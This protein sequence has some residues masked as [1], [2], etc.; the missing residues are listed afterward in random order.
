[1]SDI[2]WKY[3]KNPHVGSN[4][5]I[6]KANK[7]KTS[8][9]YKPAYTCLDCGRSMDPKKGAKKRHHFAHRSDDERNSCKGEGPKH[10][11]AKI[12]LADYIINKKKFNKFRVSD[13]S[14]ESKVSS[15]LIAD[16]KIAF[17]SDEGS[18]GHIYIEIVDSNPPCEQK[19]IEFEGKM[20]VFKISDYNDDEINDNYFLPDF[21]KQF[22]D[23]VCQ[24]V[25]NQKSSKKPKCLKIK[26]DGERCKN[27]PIK[28]TKH[29]AY[30]TKGHRVLKYYESSN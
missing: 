18:I 19:N 29:C 25:K 11:T 14:I 1:M 10:W 15:G 8:K 12:H 20:I 28:N 16:L 7:L 27:W 6:E 23:F 2:Q 26:W 21:V 3:A 30:H 17:K 24:Y 4:V 5:S 22:E 9:K 13:V